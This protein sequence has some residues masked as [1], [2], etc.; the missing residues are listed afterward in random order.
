MTSKDKALIS[1]IESTLD[2][3][4]CLLSIDE[5]SKDNLAYLIGDVQRALDE[6]QEKKS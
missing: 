3:L 5:A 4:R 1:L 2:A 6:I